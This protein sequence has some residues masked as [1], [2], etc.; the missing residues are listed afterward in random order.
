MCK[1]KFTCCMH[2]VKSI[3]RLAN[4][5]CIRFYMIPKPCEIEYE[6]FSNNFLCVFLILHDHVFMYF[7]LY[8]GKIK[9]TDIWS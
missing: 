1:I 8:M 7:R 2:H 5:V 6:N 9:N 3:L 4:I